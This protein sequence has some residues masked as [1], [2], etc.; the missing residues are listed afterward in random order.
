MEIELKNVSYNKYLKNINIKFKTGE[1]YGIVGKNSLYIKD[2]LLENINNYKGEIIRDASSILYIDSSDDIFFTTTVKDEIKFAC[3]V[4]ELNINNIKQETIELFYKLGINE[5]LYNRNIYDLSRSEKYL[6]KIVIGFISNSNVIVF[7]D[8]F[9]TLDLRYRKKLKTFIDG[10]VK[11]KIIIIFGE[12][13]DIMYDLVNYIYIIKDSNVVISGNI[14]KVYQNEKELTKYKVLIPSLC[15][16][17][18]K[19]KKKG[20]KLA[21]RKDVRDTMKDIYR[22]V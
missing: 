2:I 9:N 6:L 4:K 21:F 13:V 1:V 15:D 5:D 7:K 19:A 3:Q 12:D 17:V 16:I 11:D 20:K 14:D 22:N 8:I 18:F 10:S